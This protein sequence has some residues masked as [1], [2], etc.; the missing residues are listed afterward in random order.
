MASSIF[1]VAL[2]LGA[3]TAAARVAYADRP[4]D[5]CQRWAADRVDRSEGTWTGNADT[6][7][8]GDVTEPGRT[9]ALK[10]LNLYRFLA[11]MPEVMT[12][13]VR[14]TKAQQCA[15]MQSVNGGLSHTPPTTWKCYT[16]DGAEASG[17]SNISSGK[18]VGSMD[19][20]MTDRN[21][22][23]VGH[24]RWV[25]SNS[26]GPVGLGSA[27]GS[28][29]WNLNGTGKAA[30]PF[31]A[32]P[33]IGPVPADVFRVNS[34]DTAGWTI[35]SDTI[36]LD[37]ATAT[38]TDAGQDRPVTV[39]VLPPNYGSRYAIKL[40][41][42]GWTSQ[43][44][45]VYA[46]ALQGASMPVAYTVEVVD[47][48]A[49]DG[50]TSGTGGAG[51]TSGID[52]GSAGRAG[53]SGAGSA[54]RAGA[55]GAGGAGTS[56]GAGGSG[57]SAGAAGTGAAGAAGNGGSGGAGGGTT[58]T[59][60]GGVGGASAGAGGAG[61]AGNAPPGAGGGVG[62]GGNGTGGTGDPTTGTGGAAGR[63]GGG[64]GEVT[65]CACTTPG[66]REHSFPLGFG[67]ITA[68][69]AMALARGRRNARG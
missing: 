31:V 6:C 55:S 62:V 15:L 7:D 40:T 49:V 8:P 64:P 5:V 12:D 60:T 54:G 27:M 9:N 23:E 46:V 2:G 44:G 43:A 18:G 4:S 29:F 21:V 56:G 65:G 25:L 41:P 52:A 3:V 61:G 1:S 32:W 17:K 19:S 68:V 37:T 66:L 26:L 57:P 38:I 63:S 35:Q 42:N 33:P 24:R 59:G 16:A 58:G 48:S 36:N 13:P 14:N 28:C 50:G 67:L 30:K 22:P 51:G 53:A 20:Y 10:I 11:E 45:H 69:A 39:A 34:L 47:C